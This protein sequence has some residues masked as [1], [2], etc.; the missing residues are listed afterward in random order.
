MY[1]SYTLSLMYILLY[2]LV[3]ILA[4]YNLFKSTLS[5][6][7]PKIVMYLSRHLHR[8]FF[9]S[10]KMCHDKILAIS[11]RSLNGNLHQGASIRLDIKDLLDEREASIPNVKRYSRVRV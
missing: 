6:E 4:F 1:Y 8:I 11:P 5:K 7:E 9:S 10:K 3:Y 2:S